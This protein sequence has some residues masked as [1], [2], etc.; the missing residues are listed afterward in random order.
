MRPLVAMMPFYGPKH[1]QHCKPNII[2]FTVSKK[3]SSIYFVQRVSSFKSLIIPR[4]IQVCLPPCSVHL[5]MFCFLITRTRNFIEKRCIFFSTLSRSFT[6]NSKSN[7]SLNHAPGGLQILHIWGKIIIIKTNRS[8]WMRASVLRI[9]A[10]IYYPHFT[11]VGAFG[12]PG[13]QQSLPVACHHSLSR[14]KFFHS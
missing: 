4:R 7:V 11:L 5:S 14:L 10:R 2:G 8:T 3:R 12:K 1:H 13:Y 6:C 9:S